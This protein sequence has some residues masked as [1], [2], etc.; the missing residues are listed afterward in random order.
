MIVRLITFFRE[1]KG[2]LLIML[3]V[4]ILVYLILTDVKNLAERTQNPQSTPFTSTTVENLSYVDV[5]SIVPSGNVSVLSAFDTIKFTFSQPI[6]EDSIRVRVVP[7]INV[8]AL[9]NPNDRSQ[10]ALTPRENGWVPGVNYRIEIIALESE[11]GDKLK[12]RITTTYKNTL[13][14]PEDIPVP[15]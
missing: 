1:K 4:G 8:S 9:V 12:E 14:A 2:L 10:V 7:T 13:P 15:F 6:K 5:L 11:N 3:A